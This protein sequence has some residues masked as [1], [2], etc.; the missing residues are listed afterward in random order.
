MSLF[1]RKPQAR[2]AII[3]IAGGCSVNGMVDPAGT[4][5]GPRHILSGYTPWIAATQ[6][7]L[8]IAMLVM[9]GGVMG[10]CRPA[11][12][13]DQGTAAQTSAQT[14]TQT[15]TPG[16]PLT[17]E[18]AVKIAITQSPYFTKSSLEIDIRRLDEADSRYGLV[19]PLTFRTYYYVN[20]PTGAG[21]GHPYSFSFS[22]DPYNPLGAYFT[23]Q[24]QKLVTQVATMKHLIL[25]S[26]GLESLG[27]IYLEL[28]FLHKLAA[29][30]KDLIQVAR[31]NLTYLENRLNIGTATSLEV[32][33]AR[34]QLELAQG[35]QEGIALSLKR[36]LNGLKNFLGLQST[37]DCTPD[38]RDSRRQVLGSFD[39]HTAS[40]EQAK[41]RSYELKALEIHKQLQAYNIRLAISKVF[42][43]ILFNTQTPDPLNTNTSYGLYVGLGLE[44]PVWDGFKRVR[45][46]SRQKAT[47]KQIDA[48]KTEKEIGLE[49]KWLNLLGGV[50]E[51]S[52]SLKNAQAL[53]NLARLK[54]HQSD[55]RYQS[56]GVP[57][58]VVLDSRKEVLA[59]QK[60]M[61]LRGLDYDKAVLNLRENSGDLG[62]SYVDANSW[63][64]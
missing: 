31:E 50:Q 7:C 10:W 33:M 17:F 6:V 35:E 25:I 28:D 2:L 63:Q 13:A 55:V 11:L 41:N 8:I 24:A 5:R 46:I 44:I 14:P 32:K 64:K 57:L 37:Q 23:L 59:A 19:P 45:D 29:C 53:E 30:Q 27:N 21:Y 61:L 3:T 56:G 15:P 40:V 22:T 18:E 58:T 62:Y 51:K 1:A 47:L 20:R 4:A 16:S 42:P 60:D 48:Q 49:D 52:V 26:K 36:S 12:G 54:A 38:L 43:T 34:Q 9:A 39:P